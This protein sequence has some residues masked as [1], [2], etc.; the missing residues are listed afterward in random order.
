MIENS[1]DVNEALIQKI[2]TALKDLR[3]GS[4]QIIVH[5]SKIVQIERT[6]KSRFEDM[7]MEKGGG[8]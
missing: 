7:W 2:I 8:I 4:V 6:E 5:N 1:R 3:Y